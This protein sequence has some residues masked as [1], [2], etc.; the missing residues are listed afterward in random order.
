MLLLLLLLLLLRL[1]TLLWRL[2][3]PS[4]YPEVSLCRVQISGGGGVIECG[5]WD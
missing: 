1:L 3:T 5:T 4:N 2:Q